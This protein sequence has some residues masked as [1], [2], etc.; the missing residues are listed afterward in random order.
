MTGDRSRRHEIV[1]VP[2]TTRTEFPRGAAPSPP[3]WADENEKML[4]SAFCVSFRT[5]KK[6]NTK[7]QGSRRMPRTLG[8]PRVEASE[9][10]RGSTN[11]PVSQAESARFGLEARCVWN[12]FE[13][14]ACRFAGHPGC[15]PYGRDPGLWCE[16][17][18]ELC[19]R[20][21]NRVHSKGDTQTYEFRAGIISPPPAPLPQEE[22]GVAR[23]GVA[24]DL[25]FRTRTAPSTPSP[26]RCNRPW[27]HH[28]RD[29]AGF[30]AQMV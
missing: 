18:S 3:A 1:I 14:R 12:L 16:T 24:L 26:K 6:F 22:R 9:P 30:P 19:R 4:S 2:V 23:R 11:P 25:A 15:A 20:T 17:P 10:R 7:A 27:R 21:R 28:R 29:V 13:V 8:S 5:S